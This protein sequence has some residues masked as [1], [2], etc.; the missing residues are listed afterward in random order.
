VFEGDQGAK[1]GKFKGGQDDVY[2]PASRPELLCRNRQSSREDT[3][4]LAAN[5]A[6]IKAQIISGK[7]AEKNIPPIVK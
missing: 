4:G 5:V 3:K 6:A 7:I 1:A 2:F